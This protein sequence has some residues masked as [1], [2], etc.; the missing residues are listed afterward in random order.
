MCFERFVPSVEANAWAPSLSVW[1]RIG[2]DSGVATFFQYTRGSHKASF[3]AS[4]IAIYSASLL[5]VAT[6]AWRFDC[7]GI[8]DPSYRKIY[9]L[10]DF[11][12]ELGPAQLE[13]E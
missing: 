7:Q 3:D 10:I 5:H 6:H 4:D 1:R 9:P 8:G 11:R 2:G 13:S 12:P